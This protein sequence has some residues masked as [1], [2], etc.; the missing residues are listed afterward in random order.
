VHV[1]APSLIMDDDLQAKSV[2]F[3]QDNQEGTRTSSIRT[4][5]S[6]LHDPRAGLLLLICAA[7]IAGGLWR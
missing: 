2:T 4:L 3:K 6:Q 5:R 1:T 7:V